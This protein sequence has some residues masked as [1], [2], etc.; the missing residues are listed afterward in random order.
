MNAV[1]LPDD[2]AAVSGGP[3]GEAL[4]AVGVGVIAVDRR[5][6]VR[7][8]NQ[9]A[10]EL[11]GWRAED[12][13]G[14]D[15]T[16]VFR[17][18][19]DV[20]GGEGDI[21][22]RSPVSR[23]RREEA[24]LVRRDGERFPVEYAIEPVADGLTV[25][26]SDLSE[27]RLMSLKIA[28]FGALDGVTGLL[29][30]TAFLDHLSSLCDRPAPSRPDAVLCVVDVDEFNLVNQSCGHEGGDD[31]LEWVAAILRESV[32]ERDVLARLGGDEFGI[33]LVDRDLGSARKFAEELQT[34][35]GEFMF[36]WREKSFSVSASIGL[37]RIG[38]DLSTVS[39][40][41]AAADQACHMAKDQGRGQL[42]VF[43]RSNVAVSRRIDEM[44]IVAQIDQRLQRGDAQ[45]F[46]Q[47]IRALGSTLP[48]LMCEVLLR[49]S[50]RDGQPATPVRTISAAERYGR[51]P[52]VDRWVIRRVL[53]SLE[54]AG[55][56]ALRRIHL[57]FIN[58]SA[59]S[60]R[61]EG[62]VDDI[63]SEL[64][65]SGIP[66]GKIGFEI[67][68][69]AAVQDLEKAHWFLQELG[70]I[71]CRVALDDFGT[72][73]A[74]YSYLKA[75][76]VE[77]VKIAGGFVEAM[78][79]SALDLAMVESINQISHVLGIQTVAESVQSAELLRRVGE[80]GV[81][82][83]QGFWIGEPRPFDTAWV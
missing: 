40:V 24:V 52:A 33:L 20:G 45:L 46:A 27:R 54:A 30:R 60:L 14:R 75:L 58:L 78:A 50:D 4:A 55:T 66:P 48:G 65:R 59:V 41:L 29:N 31:L 7:Y 16:E 10:Q 74:S 51:M 11:T 70:S 18:V 53:R 32:G 12:G 9:F 8:L 36:T 13:V 69:T 23:P 43:E 35:F 25:V 83:A 44:D 68:E 38:N 72:G 39:R 71:G 21:T 47:P 67:T 6:R 81:D 49:I 5:G 28:R 22:E 61:D 77:Y 37:A 2:G 42:Q 3:A 80:I 63:R 76:P 34:R 82:Y 17:L 56:E 64:S 79:H 73:V 1:N 15:V 26:F 19:Y 62:V 57:V